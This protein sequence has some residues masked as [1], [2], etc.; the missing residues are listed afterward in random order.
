MYEQSEVLVC[1]RLSIEDRQEWLDA[2][3]EKFF[4]TKHYHGHVSVLIRLDRVAVDALVELLT[5]AWASQASKRL[6]DKLGSTA[7]GIDSI[8]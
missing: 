8:N 3:P 4:T 2:D 5:E 7:A 6:R 1:W